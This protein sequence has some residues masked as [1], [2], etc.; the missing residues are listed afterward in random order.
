MV[1]ESNFADKRILVTG[2]TGSIGKELARALLKSKPAV[3]RV[4]SN[5]ENGLYEMKQEFGN[6]SALR[7]LQGD[8]RDRDRLMLALRDIDIVFHAAALKHVPISEYNPFEVVHTN[9]IGTQNLL[10]ASLLR[11]VDKFI[12]ISTDKAVNPTSTLGASKLLC[13]RLVM[14]ASS[15]RGTKL[16]AF[17]CVRFG[18]V[19]GTRGSVTNTF[20]SQIARG[21]SVTVTDRR[22]TRF[23]MLPEH[24]IDLVLK[25]AAI[26]SGGEIFIL[27]M[28][29]ARIVDLAQA[30]IDELAPKF[31][32]T[33][34]RITIEEIGIRAG[35]KLNEELMTGEEG[36][37]SF[38][39]G[40]LYVI[41]PLEQAGQG[42]SDFKPSKPTSYTS[43]NVRMLTYEELRELC[44]HLPRQ[45]SSSQCA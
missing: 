29:A 8:I 14:D 6:D 28:N 24:A 43:D 3:I 35:E 12:L 18:N 31:G 36:A 42:Y 25:S 19:L 32:F 16:G 21:R 20:A 2:G 38:E 34:Q 40:D 39:S 33:P 4:L 17:S 44:R 45:N 10:E 23:V 7:F 11:G 13:E 22:M 1:F 41:L 9:V 27:K 15:Y 37:R 26:A 30:M 5:D